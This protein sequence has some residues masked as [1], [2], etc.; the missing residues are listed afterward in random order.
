[1][2]GP[3]IIGSYHFAAPDPADDVWRLRFDRYDVIDVAVADV[4]PLRDDGTTLALRLLGSG[5]AKSVTVYGR[6]IEGTR[7]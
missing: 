6:D 1:M 4:E 3:T 2:A 7:D 5:V